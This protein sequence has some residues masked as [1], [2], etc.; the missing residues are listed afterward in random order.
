MGKGIPDHITSMP[1]AVLD[2]PIGRMMLPRLTAGMNAR[3]NGLH[4]L[5]QTAASV[6]E[7]MQLNKV[8]NAIRMED[9]LDF[10]Q[11][12]KLAATVVFFTSP[13]CPPCRGLYPVYDRLAEHY[14]HQIAFIKVDISLAHAVAAKYNI[15][16]TPTFITLFRGVLFK[17]WVGADTNVLRINIHMMAQMGAQLHIHDRLSVPS[18]ADVEVPPVLYPKTPPIAKLHIK[19]G[20]YSL[21]PDIQ[22]LSTFL[23]I[24]AK[25][26]AV[27][28]KLPGLISLG[29]C[30]RSALDELPPETMFTAIDMFRAALVDPRM[31]AYYAEERDFQTIDAIVKWV[32]KKGAN[33]PYSMRLV[34]LHTL[35]NMFSTPLLANVVF[36]DP[37]IRRELTTL[38]SSSFLDDSHTN[39]RVAAS[40]LLF[41]LAV[42]NRK[43]RREK[44]EARFSSEEEVELAASLVE[45]IT[46]ETESAE[47]LHGMLLSLGHLMFGI[48]LTG[49]LADLLRALDAKDIVMGKEKA[50]PDEKLVQEVGD[51]LLDKGLV[52]P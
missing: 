39:T 7:P 26:T 11:K 49:E 35:C 15:T 21:R 24:R 46:Q 45:A 22:A 10:L 6:A 43:R 48:E 20:S 42:Q 34:T 4:G 28:T 3:R 14:G 19:M 41:N 36:G 27:N 38:V 5:G 17:R 12:S 16:A 31:S 8:H 18:L 47:A 40:S 37:K 32:N 29:R 44:N 52:R 51:E 33:C 23:E 1:Q 9:Y 25:N 2:S 50:F 30:I 13:N